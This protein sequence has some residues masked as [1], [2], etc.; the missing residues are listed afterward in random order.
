M[1]GRLP[2]IT[3]A[4]DI[5]DADPPGLL[6]LARRYLPDAVFGASDGI[7]TTFAV[8]CGVVGAGLAT[9]IILI[10]GI[11]NLLADG[12]SMAASNYLA[13]RSRS[14]DTMA[15]S[16]PEA[17]RHGAVTFAAFVL[18][19]AVALVAFIV[20]LPQPLRTPVAILLT[21]VALLGV[22]TVR[23]VLLG[24]AWWRSGLEMLLVGA[25]AAGVAYLAGTLVA[26]VTSTPAT[27]P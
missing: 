27:V 26:R 11:A 10:L 3:D 16:R 20:P 24:R 21:L 12:F 19:G 22:G 13:I 25:M 6:A 15:P 17:A 8:I 14:A 18:A 2:T 7:I 1:E 23:G 9:R 5:H 4:T